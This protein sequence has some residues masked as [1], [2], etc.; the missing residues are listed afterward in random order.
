[1]TAIR[2]MMAAPSADLEPYVRN[3]WWVRP[4]HDARR[5][6]KHADG[7]LGLELVVDVERGTRAATATL[8]WDPSGTE[9]QALHLRPHRALL[10][11]RFEPSGFF[12]LFASPVGEP[13]AKALGLCAQGMTQPCRSVLCALEQGE[14][15]QGALEALLRERLRLPDRRHP[16]VRS[17][18]D[19][20]ASHGGHVVIADLVRDASVSR[21]HFERLFREQVGLSPAAFARL[22]QVDKARGLLVSGSWPLARIA[23]ECGFF[24][25][26]HLSREFRRAMGT[27]PGAYRDRKKLAAATTG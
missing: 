10:G 5:G 21:R 6:T 16:I 14:A 7:N 8:R 11:V 26:A 19:G 4:A 12:R 22:A 25:Q 3:F 24:D 20:I 27:S 17:A 15:P 13:L 18:I 9:A 1:M 2:P 23:Q